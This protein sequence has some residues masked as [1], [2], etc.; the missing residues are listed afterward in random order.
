MSQSTSHSGISEKIG[1]IPSSPQNTIHVIGVLRKAEASS[2]GNG[3]T[4]SGSWPGA[5]RSKGSLRGWV[6]TF[7]G[8]QYNPITK[9]KVV[10]KVALLWAGA[11]SP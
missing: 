10:T 5:S 9:S 6:V 4:V 2:G 8:K 3:E 1:A 11:F 7:L